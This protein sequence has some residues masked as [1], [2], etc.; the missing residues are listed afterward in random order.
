[1]T[2]GNYHTLVVLSVMLERL[3]AASL[4]IFMRR[5]CRAP[6]RIGK[7]TVTFFLQLQPQRKRCIRALKEN[8]ASATIHVQLEAQGC[9]AQQ[10][11]IASDDG[12]LRDISLL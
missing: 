2:F 9:Q 3:E 6:K 10:Q 11:Q 12:Y 5:W 8:T 7:T 4:C 1:M